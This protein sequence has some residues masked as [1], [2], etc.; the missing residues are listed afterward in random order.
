KV[1]DCDFNREFREDAKLRGTYRLMTIR[2]NTSLT[3][4]EI[5]REERRS[6]GKDSPGCRRELYCEE[7]RD[8]E[9]MIIPEFD[10]AVHVVE[11]EN[12]PMP[13]YALAY[14]GLDPGV[15]D[16]CGLVWFYFD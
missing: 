9:T 12:W 14:T 10:E 11:P 15:T 8:E 6:G 4:E 7:I 16:P 2:G 13:R 3:E 1:P 5:A